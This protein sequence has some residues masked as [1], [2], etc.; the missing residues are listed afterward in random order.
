MTFYI[1]PGL[2][3]IG[4][5]FIM[6]RGRSLFTMIYHATIVHN[7]RELHEGGDPMNSYAFPLL[8]VLFG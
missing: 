7:C 3:H 1:L 2:D 5:H 6:T 4:S 8:A